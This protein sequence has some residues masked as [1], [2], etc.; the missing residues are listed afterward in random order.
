MPDDEMAGCAGLLIAALG[1]FVVGPA[2]G[3]FMG[4]LPDG[5]PAGYRWLFVIW[6]LSVL[7]AVPLISKGPTR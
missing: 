6:G 4:S 1:I 5:G 3:A 2:V 7:F